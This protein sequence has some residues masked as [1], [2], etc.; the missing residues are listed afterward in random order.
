MAE[1]IILNTDGIIIN[2][3]KVN[4]NVASNYGSGFC[5]DFDTING[6]GSFVEYNS[7]G[8][9]SIP[10]NDTNTKPD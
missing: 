7:V 2:D 3:E 1:R 5:P 8:Q 9:I 4:W 6:S 10:K